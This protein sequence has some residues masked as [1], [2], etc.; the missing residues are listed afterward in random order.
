M[1]SVNSVVDPEMD[2][3]R[4]QLAQAAA[5]RQAAPGSRG[6]MVGQVRTVGNQA[7]DILGK[8]AA[9]FLEK[10][11]MDEQ[12]RIEGER[13]QQEQ[14]WISQ[15]PEETR[16]ITLPPDQA[17]PVGT[18]NKTPGQLAGEIRNWSAQG[19]KLPN[20]P[21]ARTVAQYGIQKGIDAPQRMLESE[22]KAED[23]RAEQEFR[24]AQAKELAAQ[25]A[26]EKAESDRQR[27]ADRAENIR[28]AA[29]LRPAPQPRE[30]RMQLIQTTDENGNPIQKIVSMEPGTTF[31]ALPKATSGDRQSAAERKGVAEANLGI[32][33][34][35]DAIAELSKPSAEGALGFKNM[36]LPET[37]RQ[38]TNPEG[39]VPRAVV[40]NIGSLKLHDRSGA[41]VTASEF[42]RL[43]PFIPTSTDTP[44][45]AVKKL[46]K[47]RDEYVRMQQEW[48][49][50]PKPSA[51]GG[52]GGEE[53]WVR[54]NGK[55]V[56]Q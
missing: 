49:S 38:Y 53:T 43:K 23:R 5:M 44:D 22:S 12:G 16:N 17:G 27:A 25:R 29:S 18:I 31:P 13:Q 8:I 1:A 52:G 19:A 39:I 42:P 56:R 34:I 47:M 54:V 10:R 30:P 35:D 4:M 9:P 48:S 21:L 50:S 7:G 3:I 51:G 20:S 41:A 37:L 15:M 45:A 33:S 24:A 26:A 46:G 28:L 6:E 36:V 55:L 32:A 11:L 40:A 2:R 14:D